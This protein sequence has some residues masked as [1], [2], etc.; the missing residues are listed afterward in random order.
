MATRSRDGEEGAAYTRLSEDPCPLCASCC[1]SLAASLRSEE[2]RRS[3][4]LGFA[5]F[6]VAVVLLRGPLLAV[7]K[8]LLK[9]LEYFAKP[10]LFV[11]DFVPPPVLECTGVLT[12]GSALIYLCWRYPDVTCPVL[13]VLLVVG[14]Y[15]ALSFTLWYNPMDN[16]QA[17]EMWANASKMLRA[18]VTALR[19]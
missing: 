16:A 13:L 2:G 7:L 12:V 1:R 14:M 19:S 3:L 11:A 6:V 10:L 17:F 4:F 15:V 8:V 9:V 5:A 18:N